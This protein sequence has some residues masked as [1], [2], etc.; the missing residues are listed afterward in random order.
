MVIDH[1]QLNPRFRVVV[2]GLL[3]VLDA[4]LIVAI[5]ERLELDP[6]IHAFAD[7]VS[8]VWIEVF[9]VMNTRWLTQLLDHMP[10]NKL[11][12]SDGLPLHLLIFDALS[13]LQLVKEAVLCEQGALLRPLREQV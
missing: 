12:L 4:A 11:V 8:L 5:V 1:H 6:L 9:N 10:F 2:R 13:H 7:D 3:I